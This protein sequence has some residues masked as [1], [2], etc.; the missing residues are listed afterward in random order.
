MARP[1]KNAQPALDKATIKAVAWQQI[2]EQGLPLLSLRGIA[3]AIGISAP[4]IYHYFDDRD[5]LVTALMVDAFMMMRTAL[6]DA[7]A[8]IP[9]TDIVGRLR[10]NFIA[11]RRW[12]IAHPNHYHLLFGQ[13]L[14]GY[15]A[16]VEIV[17]PEAGKT[18]AT[19]VMLIEA[20]SDA[21][22]LNPR[23]L[24]VIPDPPPAIFEYW[25]TATGLTSY[26]SYIAAQ[27]V[28]TRIHGVVSV[29][30][31]NTLPPLGLEPEVAFAH[32]IDQIIN[33]YVLPER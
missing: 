4:A 30:I 19:L 25:R 14:A 29:E 28:W 9:T 31:S 13:T 20:I 27:A 10:A 21:G 6:V 5:A 18:M 16:P 23:A 2:S 1:K 8:Q 32:T 3:R 11:Y 7:I 33:E 15:V 22:R 24:P 12:A 17:G 26:R